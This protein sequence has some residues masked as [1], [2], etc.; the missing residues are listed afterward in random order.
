MSRRVPLNVR[1]GEKGKE[2]LMLISRENPTP[3][4]ISDVVRAALV[5]ARKYE[6]EVVAHLKGDQK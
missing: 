6:K 2:W 4:G 3:G 1:V 5:V